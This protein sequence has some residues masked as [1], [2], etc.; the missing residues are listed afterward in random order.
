MSCVGEH[1]LPLAVGVRRQHGVPLNLGPTNRALETYATRILF[2]LAAVLRVFCH[3]LFGELKL[4]LFVIYG[5]TIMEHLLIFAT[6]G[7][8]DTGMALPRLPKRERLVLQLLHQIGI[9][10]FSFC[11]FDQGLQIIVLLPLKVNVFLQVIQLAFVFV[12][13]VDYVVFLASQVIQ[14]ILLLLLSFF[15]HLIIVLLLCQLLGLIFDCSCKFFFHF[16][17]HAVKIIIPLLQLKDG[18]LLTYNGLES[19]AQ[20]AVPHFYFLVDV[21]VGLGRFTV[22]RAAQKQHLKLVLHMKFSDANLATVEAG[23]LVFSVFYRQHFREPPLPL[24]T[25]SAA[26]NGTELAETEL[27][28]F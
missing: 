15:K 28:F 14:I 10:H 18:F 11:L 4:V 25:L 24:I 22:D 1:T 8:H 12:V 21:V 16:I 27:F 6:F 23:R 2:S 5:D 26:R 7:A 20:I 19:E 3:A 9:V 17:M 13:L